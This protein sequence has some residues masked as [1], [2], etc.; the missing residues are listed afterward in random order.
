MRPG[1]SRA[2]RWWCWP[3]SASQC[4]EGVVN[5]P[6]SRAL[7]AATRKLTATPLASGPSVTGALCG[8]ENGTRRSQNAV[9]VQARLVVRSRK[10]QPH[11]TGSGDGI[12]A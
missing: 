12:D 6:A 5:G 9:A 7:T 11:G 2:P 4:L 3:A 8:T 10:R 1:L